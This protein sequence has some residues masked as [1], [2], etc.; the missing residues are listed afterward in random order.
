M[1]NVNNIIWM[2]TEDGTMVHLI[3]PSEE[4]VMSPGW[5]VALEVE[6]FNETLDILQNDLG[7]RLADGPGER[8]DGQKYAFLT[9]PDGNRIEITS[10]NNLR[11]TRRE[12]DEWGRGHDIKGRARS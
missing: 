9:D 8:I 7:C 1:V 2:S 10:A 12:V 11:P 3:E 5:H 6:N 4:G